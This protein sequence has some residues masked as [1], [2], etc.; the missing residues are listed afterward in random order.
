MSDLALQTDNSSSKITF[1]F[2]EVTSGSSLELDKSLSRKVVN[3]A[4]GLLLGLLLV[5]PPSPVINLDPAWNMPELGSS[6]TLWQNAVDLIEMDILP[7][8][9]DIELDSPVW[10]SNII[11]ELQEREFTRVNDPRNKFK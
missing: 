8:D 3:G 10:L 6:S 11:S 1:S 5:N 4:A 7:L 2:D 9:E